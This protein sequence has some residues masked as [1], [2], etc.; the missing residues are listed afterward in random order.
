MEPIIILAGGFWTERSVLKKT[1]PMADKWNSFLELL[2]QNLIKNGFEQ[3]ILS[4]HY[5]VKWHKL[6]DDK[7]YNIKYVIEPK[8]LELEVLFHLIN[9]FWRICLYTKRW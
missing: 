1:K 9:K 4:L 6:F 8:P 3:F 5:K 2:I 7:N